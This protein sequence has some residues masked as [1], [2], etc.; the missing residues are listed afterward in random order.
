MLGGSFLQ[1]RT[2][3]NCMY[4]FPLP[5]QLPITQLPR[6]EPSLIGIAE[7][8]AEA[9]LGKDL[10]LRSDSRIREIFYL[11]VSKIG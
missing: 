1:Y 8:I 7:G 4:W 11:H 5:F 10:N 6:F 3:T 2:L 9:I